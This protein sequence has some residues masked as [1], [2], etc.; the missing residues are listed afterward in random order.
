M[1]KKAMATVVF[2]CA[3]VCI[4]SAAGGGIYSAYGYNMFIAEDNDGAYLELTPDWNVHYRLYAKDVSPATFALSVAMARDFFIKDDRS[5]LHWDY[6][7]DYY[8]TNNHRLN[9][10]VLC[11]K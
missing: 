4:V 7:A 10:L 9:F 8:G 3:F 2:I 6:T 5:A 11:G 1:F